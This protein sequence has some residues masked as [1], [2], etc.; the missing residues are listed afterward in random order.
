MAINNLF[1]V[2]PVNNRLEICY[3]TLYYSIGKGINIPRYEQIL[4]AQ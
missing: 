2:D 3:S 4:E 1:G